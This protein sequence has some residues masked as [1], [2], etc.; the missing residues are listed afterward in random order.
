MELRSSLHL[1]VVAIEKGAFGSHSTKIAKFTY[2][3]EVICKSFI[4]NLNSGR[5]VYFLQS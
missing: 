4:H 2:K 1:G 3:P 5:R